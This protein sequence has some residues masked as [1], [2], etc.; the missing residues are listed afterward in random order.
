M[1]ELRHEKKVEHEWVW[2]KDSCLVNKRKL[3]Y[4]H[5]F[6]VFFLSFLTYYVHHFSV[7]F[8]P[9]KNLIWTIDD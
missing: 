7:H 9:F 5:P 2:D 3:R 4:F 1:N 6:C 8:I